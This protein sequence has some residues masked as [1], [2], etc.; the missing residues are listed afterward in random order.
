[1]WNGDHRYKDR[2]STDVFVT[3]ETET[4]EVE[5]PLVAEPAASN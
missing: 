5:L 4:F 2:G 1:M 3:D